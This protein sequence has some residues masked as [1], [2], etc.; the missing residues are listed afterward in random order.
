MSCD[1]VNLMSLIAGTWL[2]CRWHFSLGN[3]GEIH[4]HQ[5][6]SVTESEWLSS[7]RHQTV[8]RNHVS[9]ANRAEAQTEVLDGQIASDVLAQDGPCSMK[10]CLDRLL[11]HP[12]RPGCLQG[13]MTIDFPSQ[14]DLS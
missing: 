3:Q 12:E 11:R 1:D 13:G 9:S 7:E 6:L 10:P 2:E 5:Q 14:E 4:I 8:A